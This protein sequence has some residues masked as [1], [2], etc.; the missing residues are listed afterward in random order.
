MCNQPVD[1]LPGD[2]A[3]AAANTAVIITYAANVKERHVLGGVV[4]SYS[5]APTGGN[6]KVEN[7]VGSTIFQADI[8]AGGPVSIVF[9]PPLAGSPN[10]AMI[11]T[12]AAG[13]GTVVGKLNCRHWTQGL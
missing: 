10:T 2:S 12:L 5:A 13:S 9:E 4:S 1:G 8:I 6:I 11:I 7:G 3:T